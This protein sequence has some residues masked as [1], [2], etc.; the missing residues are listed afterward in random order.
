[1]MK[2]GV[3]PDLEILSPMTLMLCHYASQHNIKT[4]KNEHAF[5]TVDMDTHGAPCI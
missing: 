2:P 4:L 5:L 3:N 1:M